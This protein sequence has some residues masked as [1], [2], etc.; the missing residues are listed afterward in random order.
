MCTCRWGVK[1]GANNTDPLY[2]CLKRNLREAGPM[3]R[4]TKRELA[5]L[6]VLSAIAIPGLVSVMLAV[7]VHHHGVH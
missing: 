1:S 4:Q 6:I 7:L 3:D 2:K 5:M